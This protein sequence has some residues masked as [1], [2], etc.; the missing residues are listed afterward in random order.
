MLC[1]TTRMIK[2]IG[3]GLAIGIALGAAGCGCMCGMPSKRKLKRRIMHTADSMG[4]ALENICCM[5]R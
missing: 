3:I 2:G 5:M 4:N 1:R